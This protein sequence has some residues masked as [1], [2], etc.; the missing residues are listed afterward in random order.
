MKDKLVTLLGWL[1]LHFVDKTSR[2]KIIDSTGH[3]QLVSDKKN[4][5]YAFWHG[6]QLFALYWLRYR[7]TVVMV[8]RSRDG[9][10]IA[11]VLH[12]LGHLTVRGSTEHGAKSRG[13]AFALIEMIRKIQQGYCSSFTP[14]GPVGP[15]YKV[16]LGTIVAAQKTGVP[17]IPFG[18]A[19]KTKKIIT[20]NWDRFFVFYPF[21]KI[22]AVFGEPVYINKDDDTQQK[23][24]ELENLLNQ[25]T[26]QAEKTVNS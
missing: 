13:G 16:Q 4:C 18:C 5:I 10:Y 9:N 1:F 21:N 17:I 19:A 25:V 15:L 12:A 23:G 7:K 8:S 22:A 26:E 6:Q 20:K 14:D 24:I 3:K 2:V 11:N